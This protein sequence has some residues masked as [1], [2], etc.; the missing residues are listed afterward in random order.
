MEGI[1]AFTVE[2][3]ADYKSLT[4]QIT[5]HTHTGCFWKKK[6]SEYV[7]RSQQTC[8]PNPH[9]TY[10]KQKQTKNTVK[11]QHRWVSQVRTIIVEHKTSTL[12]VGTVLNFRQ[13]KRVTICHKIDANQQKLKSEQEI[14]LAGVTHG[15]HGSCGLLFR[16]HPVLLQSSSWIHFSCSQKAM[17][18]QKGQNN[19][20]IKIYNGCQIMWPTFQKT[21]KFACNDVWEY[22][23]YPRWPV[24][25]K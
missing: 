5:L 18:L 8:P 21:I 2:D 1:V 16:K 14:E 23:V 11:W 9:F 4:I 22:W 17:Q 15:E 10:V 19:I 6:N 12:V 7:T 25:L 3:K 20:F 13:Q 24:P